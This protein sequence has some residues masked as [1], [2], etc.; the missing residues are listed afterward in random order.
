MPAL[1]SCRT[2]NL[3]TDTDADAPISISVIGD[4]DT[5]ETL[6]LFEQLVGGVSSFVERMEHESSFF[7]QMSADNNIYRSSFIHIPTQ[8]LE[9]DRPHFSL[10]LTLLQQQGKLKTA[11]P[12][13]ILGLISSLR[14]LHQSSAS[15]EE[16]QRVLSADSSDN[17]CFPE[18]LL[19][20]WMQSQIHLNALKSGRS[21]A[22]N[23]DLDLSRP[24]LLVNGRVTAALKFF[25]CYC[26]R[27][28]DNRA[29]RGR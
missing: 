4:M 15:R 5:E 11:S 16:A 22:K 23:L 1:F 8:P 26:S 24:Y 6:S 17:L 21:L 10:V 2:H 27:H 29:S 3:E 19:D 20:Q 9:S 25:D 13:K 7:S 18:I 14:S 12:E 28:V